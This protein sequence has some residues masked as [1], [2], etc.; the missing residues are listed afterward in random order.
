MIAGFSDQIQIRRLAVG[1]KAKYQRLHTLV[2]IA[3]TYIGER[4]LTA[5][6]YET[7]FAVNHLGYF[8]LTA[9]L[10]DLPKSSAPARVV[11]VASDA[12]SEPGF[13]RRI[14][15]LLGRIKDWNNTRK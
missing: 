6:G 15:R 14:G 10:I 11:N 12:R 1:V 3:G 5:D 7:T 9:E 2:N 4:T 8:L 13:W